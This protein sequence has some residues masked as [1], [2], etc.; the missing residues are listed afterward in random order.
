MLDQA[1][2]VYCT[3]CKDNF[4]TMCFL[5]VHRKGSRKR[6][7]LLRW[8]YTMQ[9]IKAVKTT[10]P[11][12]AVEAPADAPGA[13]ETPDESEKNTSDVPV[14]YADGYSGNSAWYLERAK[15]SKQL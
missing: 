11:V 12:D 14:Q 9:S 2:E 4:C 15:Y 7:R 1:S 3:S 6:H 10:S 5:S 13:S 8:P